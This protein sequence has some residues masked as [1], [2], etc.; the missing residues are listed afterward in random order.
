VARRNARRRP[1]VLYNVDGNDG[2]RIG[3]R[4]LRQVLGFRRYGDEPHEV[5]YVSAN[6]ANRAVGRSDDLPAMWLGN[7]DDDEAREL[8]RAL[9]AAYRA[10]FDVSSSASFLDLYHD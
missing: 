7:M 5:Q 6:E 9:D 4:A 8:R 10:E 3:G 1:F 2:R